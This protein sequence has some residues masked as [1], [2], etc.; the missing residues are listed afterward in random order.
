MLP[1]ILCGVI[2]VI[3]VILGIIYKSK[4]Q[5]SI[6]TRVFDIKDKRTMPSGLVLLVESGASISQP[7]ID[8]IENGLNECFE[9]ARGQNYD[10]PLNLSDYQVAI[11]GDSVRAPESQQWC[12][13]LPIKGSGY[14]GTEWDLGGY[15]L[16]AGQTIAA[17]IPYG[18]IIAL[19]DHHGTDL[20]QLAQVAGYEAEH[21]ILAHCDGDKY[22]AT[23]VHG[24][25]QG[26]PL[27]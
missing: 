13:K 16:A 25:G 4:K 15:L 6:V 14:E 2:I 8:A 18:N 22:E 3:A 9:R 10:R 23:K 19:P 7:E 26:H 1:I 5:K 27:F 20:E 21:V 17:G 11:I 12:Y 24:Q